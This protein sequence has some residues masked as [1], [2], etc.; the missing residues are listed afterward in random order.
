MLLSFVFL[1]GAWLDYQYGKWVALYIV[2]FSALAFFLFQK[3]VLPVLRRWEVITLLVIGVLMLG[4]LFWFRPS[5]YEFS[6]LDRLSFFVLAL[7]AWRGFSSGSL[8]WRDFWWPLA[9][10]LAGVSV[11]GL[12]QVA[13]IG[14]PGEMPYTKM[15][16]TFGHAN[17]S[18]QFVGISLLLWWAIPRRKNRVELPVL[19][20]VSAV[21]LSY[22][23]LSRGRSAL[24]AFALGLGLMIFLRLK[25]EKRLS[26][27]FFRPALTALTIALI[28]FVGLQLVKGKSLTEV[29]TFSIFAEKPSIHSY[30]ADVWKQTVKMIQAHPL[31]VGLDRFAFE[32]LPFH[33]E[34]TTISY[35]H[36][37]VSPHNEF[38]RFLAE[39]GIPL[40]LLYLA[41]WVYLIWRWWR[42]GAA[43]K[44]ILLPA[45]LFFLSEMATQ[46]PWQNSYPFFL[47]AVF[48]GAMAT[49][50][51]KQEFPTPAW[52]RASS[53]V[54]L[55]F[56]AFLTLKAVVSR[57]FETS[58]DPFWAKTSCR[59]V[60]SNWQACLNYTRLLLA[61]GE[62][63][64]ARREVE[65]LLELE[66]WNY[67]AIRHLAVIAARQGDQLEACFHTWRYDD[68]FHGS[69][70]L[71]VPFTQNCPAK[72]R[73]YFKRKRPSKYYRR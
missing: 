48:T 71:K 34:G 53:A 37:A 26:F 66:P 72:W 47:G 68:L 56:V 36:L 17:N 1:P 12:W 51:G 60:P 63:T 31:G 42:A 10:A 28:S 52:A 13:S 49:G 45:G 6:L 39:E 64:A 11:Y 46:F 65:T 30:R 23:V 67:A 55:V 18:A 32:F 19:V 59:A 3:P 25:A 20:L 50:L 5:G 40:A 27:R 73:E 8:R 16:S 43:H 21:S 69:S 38:L 29:A 2:S 33:K 57:S 61:R 70:D 44:E 15:G 22:L 58:Q 7:S 41:F 24:L 54:L 4:H 14:F 62:A 35:T 9:L